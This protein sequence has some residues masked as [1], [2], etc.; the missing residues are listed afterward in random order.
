M[1]VKPF[2]PE[3]ARNRQA[4]KIPDYVIE[5]VNELI[6]S[7]VSPKGL[8][9]FYIRRKEIEEK[10]IEMKVGVDIKIS[11]EDLEIEYLYGKYG[12]DVSWSDECNFPGFNFKEKKTK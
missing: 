7:H 10:V 3:E 5:A 1:S 2:T 8:S 9:E 11:S 12:W 6:A 4:E